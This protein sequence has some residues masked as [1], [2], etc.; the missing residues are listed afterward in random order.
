MIHDDHWQKTKKKLEKTSPSFCL[1]KWYQLTLHLQNGHN[2]SC[3]HPITH[4][5]PLVEVQENPHALHNSHYKKEVRSQMLAGKQ[6]S[7]CSYCWK[8]EN[9]NSTQ[10]SDRIYKS[11]AS[12]AQDFLSKKHNAK[13]DYHPTYLEVSFGNEC[14]LRCAYCSPHISSALWSEYEKHGPYPGM[15]DLDSIKRT[16]RAPY[17]EEDNPYLHAFWKWFP[18]IYKGLKHLRITGGEP[19][20]N[21]HTEKFFQFVSEHPMPQVELSLNS[22]LMV[23]ESRLSKVLN[24]VEELLDKKKIKSFM[25]FSSVDTFGEQAEYIRFGLDYKKWL[26][27]I[28][29]Y[30]ARFKLPLTLMVTFNIFSI[31]SFDRLLFDIIKLKKRL[32]LASAQF[33]VDISQLHYPAT[34]SVEWCSSYQKAI[35]QSKLNFMKSF[36]VEKVGKIGFIPEELHKLER[37]VQAAGTDNLDNKLIMQDQL[38]EFIIEHDRRKGTQFRVAFPNWDFE[39]EDKVQDKKNE[40]IRPHG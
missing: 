7:E 17:S 3:H 32:N 6:V 34:L 10:M 11:G 39:T 2:H 9:I 31:D 12:W 40:A 37:I 21:S 28:E 27:A 19:L 4:Q 30:L 13:T 8:V 1:A 18:Q 15:E 22:N 24:T 16:G 36:S 38:K 20:I 26:K 5:V 14:N 33:Y 29:F 35:L 25:L 23:S